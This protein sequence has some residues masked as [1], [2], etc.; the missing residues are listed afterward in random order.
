M[1]RAASQGRTLSEF[2]REE[3]L[4]DGRPAVIRALRPQDRQALLAALDRASD[5]TLYTRFFTA[6]H[7]LSEREIRGFVEVD[8][9]GHVALVAE[10]EL[11]GR[12]E[13]VGG[14]RYV[15]VRPGEAELAFA[16]VDEY[17][18]QGLGRLLL[19]HLARL[20]AAS[21]IESFVA[22]VL[23][24]NAAMLSVFRRSGLPM[25][26]ER[27]GSELHVRLRV[28]KPADGGAA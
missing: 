7:A 3:R 25:T 18:G 16:I 9:V 4:R 11:D 10:V 26:I 27:A 8:F 12:R 2:H 1:E 14:G 20:A 19:H 21:G 23:A 28:L 13:I 5:R 22:D 17:Q 24:A 15:T 6:R